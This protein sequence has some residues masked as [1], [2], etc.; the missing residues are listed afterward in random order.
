M[1]RLAASS[2]TLS[3]LGAEGTF[4]ESPDA[5]LLCRLHLLR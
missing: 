4:F 1:H 3:V 5:A 2:Y